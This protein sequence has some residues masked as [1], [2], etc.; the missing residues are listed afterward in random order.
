MG[1][2][3]G[4][5]AGIISIAERKRKSPIGVVTVVTGDVTAC[6]MD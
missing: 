1:E 4:G 5:K 2:M 3:A 6:R